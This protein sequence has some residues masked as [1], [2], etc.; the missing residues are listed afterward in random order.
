MSGEQISPEI[1]ENAESAKIDENRLAD[2]DRIE[3][4][5]DSAYATGKVDRA[6]ITKSAQLDAAEAVAMVGIALEA[7]EEA[8]EAMKIAVIAEKSGNREKAKTAR[9]KEREARKKANAEHAA[10]TKSAKNAYDAIKFSAP[11]KMGFMRAVQVLFAIH[12]GTVL[13]WLMLTNRD[14]MVYNVSTIMDWIMITLEALCFWFFINRYRIARPFVI[15]MAGI[16]LLVPAAVDVASGHFNPFMLSFNGMFYIFL[17]LYFSLS[18]RVKMT[19]VNDF[20][21]HDGDYE[22]DDF[23]VE[24]KGWPFIRN[25]I[26]YFIVFST[27][28]SFQS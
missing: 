24:R 8:D 18:K 16:G 6:L 26:M 20:S 17:I 21:K 1:I 5:I 19:L 27:S 7:D 15:A 12:I 4:S 23:T 14:A 2:L 22:H 25:L 10:A 11:N 28:S 9:K 3:R 13:V